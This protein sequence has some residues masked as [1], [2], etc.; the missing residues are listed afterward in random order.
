MKLKFISFFTLLNVLAIPVYAQTMSINSSSMRIAMGENQAEQ[1]STLNQTKPKPELP[2]QADIDAQINAAK[3]QLRNSIQHYHMSEETKAKLKL[4]PRFPVVSHLTPGKV[5][6]TNVSFNPRHLPGFFVIGDDRFSKK[7]LK[8]N[9]DFIKQ[10]HLV[11]FVTN[12]NTADT[13]NA[14]QSQFHIVLH[15][16]SLDGLLD[17]FHVSHYPF[18]YQNGMINQ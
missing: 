2:S 18:Y 8:S 3:P 15:P 12:I 9:I 10:A 7:W 16:I 6:P 14:L 17:D 4:D 5:T 11:G 13:F 1:S